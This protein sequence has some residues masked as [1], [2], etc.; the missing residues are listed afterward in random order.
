MHDT[1]VSRSY[2][3][4]QLRQCRVDFAHNIIVIAVIAIKGSERLSWLVRALNPCML[5][6]QPY[7]CKLVIWW[8]H[9][10]AFW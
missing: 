3:Q 2:R 9:W 1:A 8:I 5:T 10:N 6:T 7:Y 4:L